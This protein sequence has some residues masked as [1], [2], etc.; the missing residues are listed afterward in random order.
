MTAF[1]VLAGALD[2][3]GQAIRP[4]TAGQFTRRDWRSS[5]SI[6]GHVRHCLDHVDALLRATASGV[7]CYDERVRGGAVEHDPALA[8]A[9]L[10]A[11]RMRLSGL[12]PVLLQRPVA[13]SA[14]ISRDGLEL[15]T[16]TSVAREV[17]FVLS[18]TVHHAAL[19]A[20]LLEHQ[21]EHLPAHFGLAPTTP[22]L[23]V[24]CA[25]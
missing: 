9:R 21:G 1:D 3:L 13:L 8:G 20:V 11:C 6:G 25:R 2:D 7:C 17:A 12:D 24:A 16:A 23:E 5:G 4:L 14:R 19:I 22:V 15:R 18:H 10:A